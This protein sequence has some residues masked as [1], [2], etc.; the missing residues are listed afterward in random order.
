[1]AHRILMM[2]DE[3]QF[4][5][6]VAEYLRGKG[7]EVTGCADRGEAQRFFE[8]QRFDL[9][10]L[11]IMIGSRINEGY[12][13]C[14]WIRQRDSEIPVIFC[15]ARGDEMDQERGLEYGCHDYVVKPYSVRLLYLRIK[16][17]VAHT[18]ALR[19]GGK[20]LSLQG[21][22]ID[23]ERKSAAVG[24]QEIYLTP[25]QFELLQALM[26]NAGQ[27]MSRE[28]LLTQVWEYGYIDDVRVVDRHIGNLRKAL[29]EKAE[30]IQTKVGYGYWF[31]RE[32]ESACKEFR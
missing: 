13:V 9:V 18:E 1:M 6:E 17:M 14:K 22:T 31:K 11:D 12:E 21:I 3:T 28:R 29:G 5:D 26:E 20:I 25:K 10:L 19:R 32:E 27:V 2:E 4:T 24:G 7:M 8:G 16:N 23:D 15:S 30:C